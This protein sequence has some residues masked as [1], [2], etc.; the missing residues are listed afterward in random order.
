M[1]VFRS[2]DVVQ[3]LVNR[4]L[5]KSTGRSMEEVFDYNLE[6]ARLTKLQAD[7][8]DLKVRQKASELAPVAAMEQILASQAVAARTKMLGIRSK[9]KSRYSVSDDVLEAVE[10]LHRE[11]L[12]E[13]NAARLP[14]ELREALGSDGSGVE[15]PAEADA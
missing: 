1:D 11:A 4:E 8:E 7:H 10:A 6:R 2:T 15:A 14:T 3:F 5:A 13:L 9:L 12:E